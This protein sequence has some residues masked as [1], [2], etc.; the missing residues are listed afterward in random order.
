M[1]TQVTWQWVSRLFLVFLLSSCS[2][3]TEEE[4][5]PPPIVPS[6][7]GTFDLA[8]LGS[9]FTAICLAH[10]PDHERTVGALKRIGFVATSVPTE[11]QIRNGVRTWRLSHTTNG[12][13]VELGR[14]V[15]WESGGPNEGTRPYNACT[16]EAF[17]IDPQAAYEAER[18]TVPMPANG[19]ITLTSGERPSVLFGKLSLEDETAWV[20]FSQHLGVRKP[21]RDKP[22][23]ECGGLDTCRTWS[24]AEFRISK[25]DD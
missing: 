21:V 18:I 14:F 1:K 9:F 5:P 24:K 2:P 19:P 8:R 3:E 7:N 17:L 23:E 6:T 13:D 16:M 25:T 12:I 4:R 11:S 15:L 22:P 10:F 20:S